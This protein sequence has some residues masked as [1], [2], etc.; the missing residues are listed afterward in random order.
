MAM[1]LGG[2]GS[3]LLREIGQFAAEHSPMI[4]QAAKSA[5]VEAGKKAFNL[6]LDQNPNFS[7]FLGHLGIHPFHT[8]SQDHH[9]TISHRGNGRHRRIGGH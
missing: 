5:V 9:K 6:V 2:L 8:R 1:V 3:L 7:S 4:Q